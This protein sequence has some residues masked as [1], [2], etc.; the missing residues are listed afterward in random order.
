MKQIIFIGTSP[1]N[2]LKGY[3]IAKENASTEILFIDKHERL[4]GAWYSDTSPNGLEIE[5]GCHIWTYCPE[6]YD[7]LSNELH[8]E[9]EN[10]K[11]SPIFKY[12]RT[13]LSY[14]L[15]TI[16]NSYQYIIK[17]AAM[18]RFSELKNI[19]NNPEISWRI[20]GKK[21]QY[22]KAG[23]PVLIERLKELLDQLSNVKFEYGKVINEVVCRDQIEVI[24]DDKKYVCDKLYT[25]SVS[26]FS[27]I[28][29]QEKEL[30]LSHSQRDYIHVLAKASKKPKYKA[31]YHRLV[32]DPIIH[33]ITDVSYQAQH[34]E[35][36]FLAG[37]LE[38]AF[39][40]CNSE[41]LTNHL[42]TY[43]IKNN[44]IDSE[45]ELTFVKNHVF[46]TYYIKPEDRKKLQNFD[47]RVECF[48]SIDLMYG[49]YY[50]LKNH[51][52]I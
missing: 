15:Y 14:P 49:F 28:S 44:V 5:C 24:T 41:E 22:P 43:L 38:D 34:K 1:I 18:F 51:Q 11:P 6:V 7:Y 12:G 37:I 9:M 33:R 35:H 47:P 4:G 19:K 21:N 23:S 26:S 48:Y 31:T 40:K 16:K 3:L 32:N 27:K 17:N 50:I 42:K 20:F 45:T 46:P 25:T 8:I 30:E 10:M 2:L 39:E 29:N 52:L 36:L 13:N